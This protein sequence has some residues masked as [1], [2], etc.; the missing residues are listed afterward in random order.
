MQQA[1]NAITNSK[2]ANKMNIQ[3]EGLNIY[4]NMD[5]QIMLEHDMID[6]FEEAFMR[7]YNS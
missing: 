6:S 5:A 7:G 2:E 4:N 3:Q 1:T